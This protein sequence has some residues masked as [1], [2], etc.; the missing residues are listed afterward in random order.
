MGVPVMSLLLAAAAYTDMQFRWPLDLPR[1]LSGTLGE[2][3]G[4]SL[5]QGIDIKTRGRTGYA[6][7]AI[8][9]GRLTRLS[10]KETGYGNM[11][12]INHEGYVSQYAHM[13]AFE[14]G[15]FSL[16]SL[17][18]L[19]KTLYGGENVDIKFNRSRIQFRKGD[20]VGYSGESG[21]GPPHLHLALREAGGSVNALKLI[22]VPDSD[23]PEIRHLFVCIERNGTTV[24]E[25]RVLVRGSRGRYNLEEEPLG[26]EEG[27]RLFLKL[28][29]HD[30][31]SSRNKVA[32]YRIEMRE[33]GSLLYR[34]TFD[35]ILWKDYRYGRLIYDPS[36]PLIDGDTNYTYFLYRREGNAF[37]GLETLNDGYLDTRPGKSRI[38]I[39]VADI[40]GNTARLEFDA[41]KKKS[42]GG[43][44]AAGYVQISRR[45]RTVLSEPGG[46][47]TVQIGPGALP[48]NCLVK[49]ER[50][51]RGELERRVLK[52][53]G[54]REGDIS[55]LY[56]LHP[57][58][59]TYNR[60][61]RIS[62]RRPA[63]I[64]PAEARGILVYHLLDETYPSPLKT[65]YNRQRDAFE[66]VSTSGGYFL[67]LRDKVAPGIY[68]PPVHNFAADDG[69]VRKIRL[70]IYDNLSGV[71]L[72]SMR[73]F[74]DGERYPFRYEG[75]RN[76][77]ELAL[78]KKRIGRGLHHVLVTFSDRAGNPSVFRSLLQFPEKD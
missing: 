27:E 31:I 61:V 68:V 58:D 49:A 28:S 9:P 70:A 48:G 42:T 37:S 7:Y 6:L 38:S 4:K 36:H 47:F 18:K 2:K 45:K 66:A 29:C 50:L 19:V 35:K 30:T 20:V 72:R 14:E 63:G 15:R 75:D 71:S 3:R 67:V 69:A 74:V 44:P 21:S 76:W 55:P 54:S 16:N 8:A 77:I 32:P 12:L 56:A 26:L 23:I 60:P 51:G 39:S 5:H 57:F 17:A 43:D 65:R 46:G 13:E 41:V 64:S 73:C 53:T 1:H 25:R 52:I 11:I 10:S 59:V 33:N 78:P 22:P 24:R 62:L 40:A 34:L